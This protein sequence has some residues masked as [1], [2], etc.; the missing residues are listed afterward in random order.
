MARMQAAGS[1][2]ILWGPYDGTGFSSGVDTPD[3][4]GQVP[5]GFD[6]HVWTNKVEV[7]GPLRQN[8]L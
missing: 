5:V 4:W 6:G 3:L 1:Q 8:G 7:I 2:V